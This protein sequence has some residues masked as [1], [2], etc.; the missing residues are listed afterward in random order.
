MHSQDVRP[1]LLVAE[2]V[3]AKDLF[4]VQRGCARR[5]S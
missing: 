4:A 2:C 1:Q 5:R 3:E